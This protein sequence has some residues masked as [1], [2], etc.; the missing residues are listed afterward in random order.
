MEGRETAAFSGEGAKSRGSNRV[1]FDC[2]P[3]KFF[4]FSPPPSLAFLERRE[5]ERI[6]GGPADATWMD[7]MGKPCGVTKFLLETFIFS[8]AAADGI[9]EEEEDARTTLASTSVPP[10]PPSLSS[11]SLCAVHN[12]SQ[13]FHVVRRSVGSPSASPRRRRYDERARARR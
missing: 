9:F 13:Y 4:S 8:D 11:L 2:T 1:G 12:S 6:C 5:R 10:R 3:P 7:R